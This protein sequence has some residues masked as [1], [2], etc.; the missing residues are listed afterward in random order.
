[1]GR[2]YK[3]EDKDRP[4]FPSHLPS[5]LTGIHSAFQDPTRR[6]EECVERCLGSW[7]ESKESRVHNGYWSPKTG[8]LYRNET[9]AG[10]VRGRGEVCLPWE[11]GRRGEAGS[12]KKGPILWEDLER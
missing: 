11:P 10:Q 2:D 5:V 7:E 4:S 3:P 6:E 9:E 12:G 8:S 1:M